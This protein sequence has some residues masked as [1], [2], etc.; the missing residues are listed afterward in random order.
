MKKLVFAIIFMIPLSVSADESQW[1]YYIGVHGNMSWSVVT[2]GNRG[3]II[4]WLGM[5]GGDDMKVQRIDNGNIRSNPSFSIT[6]GR[7]KK[8]DKWNSQNI[9]LLIGGELFFDYINKTI[10]QGDQTWSWNKYWVEHR[11][12]ENQPIHKTNFLLGIR[13]KVGVSLYD[14]FD[15]YGD[16][17][18][19]YWNRKYYLRE[20]RNSPY[21]KDIWEVMQIWP[22]LPFLGIGANFHITNSWAINA[23]YMKV[24]PALYDAQW[25]GL[26]TYNFANSRT[27]VG[28]DV[29]NIGILYYF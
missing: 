20:D 10:I 4:N 18:V 6:A 8:I 3:S 7:E 5:E 14:T 28:L 24:L 9:K 16:A 26:N 22:V 19:T 25:D 29:L 13:G 27:S 11:E 21:W 17:G 1:R 2:D 12:N 15:I 23:S